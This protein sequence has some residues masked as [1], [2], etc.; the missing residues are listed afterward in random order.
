MLTKVSHSGGVEDA[1]EIL[2]NTPFGYL[3]PDAAASSECLLPKSERCEDA[4]L[5]LGQAMGDASTPPDPGLDSATPA[6]FTYLGQFI[7]HDITARTDRETGL[8]RIS[9][10][11]G[12]PLP[13][14]PVAPGLVV[15]N[16]RNGRRPQL[17][18]DSLY[19]DGPGLVADTRTEASNLYDPVTGMLQL[20]HLG[21]DQ[22]DL[23]RDGRRARIGDA[24]NDENVNVSQLHAAFAAFHNRVVGLLGGSPEPGRRYARARQIVRWAYQ[25]IVAHDYL[26]KVCD[27]EVVNDTLRNGPYFFGPAAS[28][29]SLY[30]PLE[31]SVAGFRFGHSMIRPSYKIGNGDPV[32]IR[33]I[34]GV[35]SEREPDD[36]LLE[37]VGG[38]WRLKQQNRVHWANYVQ[39]T[40]GAAPQ[41]AR[42][43]DSLISRGLFDLPFEGDSGPAAMIRHLA[44]RN[45]LRGYLLSIPTGQAMASAMGVIP[46]S[47]PDLLDGESAEIVEAIELGRFQRRTPLWYY[48]LREA[49]VQTD[50]ESLG[51]VGSRL[52]SETLLGLLKHDPNSFL[53]N[54]AHGRVRPSGIKV[55]GRRDPIGTLAEMIDYTELQK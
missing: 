41:M 40:G 45:L 43:I 27:A 50:G 33:S 42:K 23:P 48:V 10:A 53:N 29:G 38:S 37:E 46:L 44:Q 13:I 31:F 39:F 18:L 21:G 14:T 35:S 24:R 19:G 51:S 8:S 47:E 49:Q 4:L 22:I 15:E 52:V 25:Y 17:D 9:Q 54:A 16:L 30:M 20:Q 28:G 5:A 3:F 26:P 36:D 12:R 1:E 6:A 55:P 34:L 32:T 7:D 2:F 11:D